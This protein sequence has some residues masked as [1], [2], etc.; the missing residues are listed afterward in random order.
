[1]HSDQAPPGFWT[2]PGE[3][4]ALVAGAEFDSS[5]RTRFFQ[6]LDPFPPAWGR[7]SWR[8]QVN[9]LVAGRAETPAF[10]TFYSGVEWNLGHAEGRWFLSAWFRWEDAGPPYSDPAVTGRV[11]LD[12]DTVL[13]RYAWMPAAGSLDLPD[14]ERPLFLRSRIDARRRI[15]EALRSQGEPPADTE[16]GVIRLDDILAPPR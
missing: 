12:G 7:L 6:A 16:P 11:R 1:M 13:F 8:V 14:L 4:S 5:V 9:Q 2:R 10:R 3:S 15:A